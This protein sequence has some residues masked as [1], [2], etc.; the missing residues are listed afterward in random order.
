MLHRNSDH[1][2]FRNHICLFFTEGTRTVPATYMSFC[3]VSPHVLTSTFTLWLVINLTRLC[4]TFV[5]FRNQSL[6]PLQVLCFLNSFAVSQ[7]I[8]RKWALSIPHYQD[9]FC[10]V[11]LYN[12]FHMSFEELINQSILEAIFFSFLNAQL[13]KPVTSHLCCT[14][15]LYMHASA[16][17]LCLSAKNIPN[18]LNHMSWR[19]DSRVYIFFHS[20]KLKRKRF[21]FF[22]IVSSISYTFALAMNKNL[23]AMLVKICTS[24]GHP[25]ILLPLLEHITH[26]LTVLTSTLW[27]P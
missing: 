13:M 22:S 17:S 5:Q 2:N 3:S 21:V 11:Q 9:F 12:N 10:I 26:H 6:P 14:K 27:S 8:L 20:M 15:F 25:L 24:G 18:A 7:T 1:L 23:H 19:S 4:C 16:K